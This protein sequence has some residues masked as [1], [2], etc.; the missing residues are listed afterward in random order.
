MKRRD[1][2][3]I[4]T[5]LLLIFILGITGSCGAPEG[6]ET[7]NESDL[8]LEYLEEDYTSQLLTD[9]AEHLVG[10]IELD[11]AEDGSPQIILH[12]KEVSSSANSD[13]TYNVSSYAINRILSVSDSLYATVSGSSEI[14]SS[15]EFLTAV[16]EDYDANGTSFDD[17]GDYILYD[18]YALEDQVL[19][20]L[21]NPT[22]V[23][24]MPEAK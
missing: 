13:G 5:L 10:S 11:V 8:T 15:G 18:V 6:D 7:L 12:P 2:F 21:Y 9:G 24:P 14:L 4:T 19:L 20:I 1:F 3:K 16:Q 17:Y 22:Y 23:L